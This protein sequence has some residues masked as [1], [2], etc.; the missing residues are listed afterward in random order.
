LEEGDLF[1]RG[2]IPVSSESTINS[3]PLDA[4]V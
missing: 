4:I 1:H 2:S 3:L